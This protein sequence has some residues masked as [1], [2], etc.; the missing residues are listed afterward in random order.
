MT[1]PI[2]LLDIDG[3]LNLL[4]KR[5]GYKPIQVE[6][7]S[8]PHRRERIRPGDDGVHYVVNI[9]L[10]V[11]D[12]VEQLATEFDIKWFTMWNYDAPDCFAPVA[13]LPHFE[14]YYVDWNMG[15]EIL[16][17][18]GYTLQETKEIWVAKTPFIPGYIGTTPFVWIDDDT[19]PTDTDYLFERGLTDFRIITVEPNLGLTQDTVNTAL[20]W[21]RARA[22]LEGS[23]P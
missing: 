14:H 17:G 15:R 23:T 6:P 2:L 16:K 10:D 18:Q 11:V 1:K 12:L 13:G 20:A 7:V 4:P 5:W 8:R 9:P 21:A 3:V 22:S 19:T